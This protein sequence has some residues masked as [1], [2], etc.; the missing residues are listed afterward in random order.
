MKRIII[1]YEMYNITNDDAK[2]LMKLKMAVAASTGE[3][4]YIYTKTR[5]ELCEYLQKLRL[6]YPKNKTH[7]FASFE[8]P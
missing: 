3:D 7:V 2:I 8:L 1:D 6:R 5:R 4:V